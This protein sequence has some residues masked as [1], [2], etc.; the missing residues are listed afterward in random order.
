MDGS[1]PPDPEAPRP[2]APEAACDAPPARAPRPGVGRLLKD[3]WRQW[4]AHDAA[5][6]GAALAYYTVFSIAPV[7]VIAVSVASAFFGEEAVRGELA[8]QLRGLLGETAAAAVQEIVARTEMGGGSGLAAVVGILALFLGAT[9]V[10][11]ELR[12]ALNTMWDVRPQQVTGVL[13]TIRARVTSFA[14]VLAIGF[15][16]LVSLAL[17]AALTALGQALS[18]LLDVAPWVLVVANEAL[19]LVVIALLFAMTYKWLPDAKIAWGDVAVGAFATSALFTVG[20]LAIGQYVGD[21]GIA[22]T[23]GAAG[24]P[25]VLLVW[26]YY[27]AQ[28]VLF[29][30]EFT[31]VWA[32]ARGSRCERGGSREP[33]G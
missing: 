11:V 7:L 23:Y 12:G 2:Y 13:A 33:D 17:S 19:S 25:V 24:S 5:R 14:L 8:A 32:R 9:S 21:S 16:L 6:L 10:F 20:K 31:Q 18:G 29:G 26:V 3:T 22:T 15:L 27:S 28:L 30:A 1:R 4:T